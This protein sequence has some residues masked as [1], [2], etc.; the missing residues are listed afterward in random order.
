MGQPGCN[1][2]RVMHIN[3]LQEASRLPPRAPIGRPSCSPDSTDTRAPAADLL[4]HSSPMTQPFMTGQ[5]VP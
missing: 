5:L 4:S 2:P 3:L 1:V